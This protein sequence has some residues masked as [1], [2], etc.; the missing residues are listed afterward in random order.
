VVSVS[1]IKYIQLED[2]RLQNK[3]NLPKLASGKEVIVRKIYFNWF[4]AISA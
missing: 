3:A 2:L 4:V 1:K